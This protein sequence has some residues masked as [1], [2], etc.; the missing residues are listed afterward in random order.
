MRVFG[1]AADGQGCGYYRL[2]V[3]LEE[4][5]AD[6]HRTLVS[7][8]MPEDWR[9]E[10]DVVVAQR[11]CN[12]GPTLTWQQL[13]QQPGRRLVFELDDDLLNVPTWN[14]GHAF[15][16]DRETRLRLK[17]N[18]Q[19]A[20]LV[21]VSTEPLAE[22]VR[23]LHPNVVVLPNCVRE[24]L[25][26]RR[27]EQQGEKVVIGWA[28]S[29]THEQDFAECGR[30]LATVL[31]H[32]W[33]AR[34]HAVGH[35]FTRYLEVRA[36]QMRHTPWSPAVEAYYRTVDFQVGIA[37]LAEHG[38]NESKSAIKALEYA[39]MGIPIV[40]SR[41]GPY[42]AFVQHEVTGYLVD[43]PR[44]WCDALFEL[45]EDRDL[46]E[47]MGAAAREQARGWTIEGN[48]HLWAKAYEGVL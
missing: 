22:L 13:A 32:D 30:A 16:A 24:H 15:F 31:K 20:H 42:A 28:G 34:F 46:R 37:P 12:P 38:F 33:R 4:L 26:G 14:P 17:A 21:T 29:S 7:G 8:R 11:T 19:V 44:E 36:K 2:Q 39:A 5:A 1:W 41:F 10:S 43:G 27:I 9:D 23:V 3:P 45:V 6:G 35:D 18:I 25:L 40:A 48:A 47:R